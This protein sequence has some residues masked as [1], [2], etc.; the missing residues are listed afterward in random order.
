M[1][2]SDSAFSGLTWRKSSFSDGGGGA[3]G[4]G[5]DCVEVAALPSG[6]ILVRHSKQTDGPVLRFTRAE[7][8]A[9]VRG[10]QAGEFDDLC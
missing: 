7:M 6:E 4:G 1:A 9:W 2:V 3:N 8:N 5:A 10:C